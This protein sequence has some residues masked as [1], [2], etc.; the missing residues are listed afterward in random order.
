MKYET[1]ESEKLAALDVAHRMVAAAKTAPKG[2]GVDKVIAFV[3]DGDEKSSISNEMRRISDQ[4]GL[5]FCNR[6]ANN[7]DLSHCIV[8]LGVENVPLGLDSC[9]FCGFD[10]CTKSLKSGSLCAFN[11][12]DLGIAIGSAVSI[13]TDN[14]MDNRVMFSI[15]K[16]ALNL[17]L[18]G[19]N[20]TVAFGIPLSI[21]SKSP[22]FDRDSTPIL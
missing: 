4:P 11:S 20:V 9:G 13:A 15:G 12:V 19:E 16:A 5:D 22:F 3:V 8:V 6:D 21:S 14:R 2:C 1:K 18:L 7:V 17:G 10:N